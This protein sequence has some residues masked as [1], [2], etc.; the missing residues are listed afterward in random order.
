MPITTATRSIRA[1]RA[2]AAAAPDFALHIA[3][4]WLALGCLGVLAIPALRGTSTWL[5]WLPFW[6]VLMPAAEC[7]L[8]RWRSLLAAS[9]TTLARVRTRR[10]GRGTHGLHRNRRAAQ[11]QSI[12]AVA[13][14]SR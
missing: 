9:R 5:G 8:L 14:L 7:M 13:L 3:A 11:R 10:R 1:P 12:W 2:P 6:L 4:A